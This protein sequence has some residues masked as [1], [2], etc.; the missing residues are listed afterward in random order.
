MSEGRPE[1][2][3]R[4]TVA[5]R[6]LALGPIALLGLAGVAGREAGSPAEEEAALRA[7][8]A[9]AAEQ[10]AAVIE[11]SDA[12]AGEILSFQL[13]LIE[14]DD[15][16]APVFAAVAAGTPADRAWRAVLEREIA[17]YAAGEDE[18]FRAR[19][20][21]L[22]DLRDRVLQALSGAEAP[23]ETPAEGA[24]LAAE[25]L[26]PSRFLE[27]DWRRFGGAALK[28]GSAASHVAMLARARG[29]PLLIGLGSA[30]ERLQPGAAAALDA[31][32]GLLL[33][34]PADSSRAAFDR[35]LRQAA[36]RRRLE[37]EFL[38][39]PA[40]TRDGQRVQALIN[41]DDPALLDRL[42]PA[43]CDGIGLARSEF[44]F[45]A[46]R[47]LPGEEA[48]FQVYRRLL[49]WAQGRPVTIRTLDAGGDKPIPGLT[50][51]GESNPFLG[52]RGLRLSLAR[53]EIFA[54]QLRALVRAAPLGDLKVM[55]PMVTRPDELLQ[56]RRLLEAALEHCRAA[57]QAAALP[58]LG[59]MVEV[60]AAALTAEDFP[61]DFY[62]IGS[63]DL[64]QYVTATG[65]DNDS[66]AALHDPRNPAVLELIGRVVA[67]GRARGVEVSLCGDMASDPALVPLLLQRGL[68]TLSAAPGRL[69]A[70]KAAV[71]AWASHG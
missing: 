20:A 24:I 52:L 27:T 2:T 63:N 48:Q 12:M 34:H 26:T 40:V 69:A 71:A 37:G 60:P 35:R 36:E 5:S 65:R 33:L 53:P 7:A 62:S 17:D 21:D 64:V 23:A 39:R 70:V 51:D 29:V 6:G 41:V 42:D 43:H 25:D 47:P 11:A 10:L 4:G 56:A 14:D 55:V 59:M 46:D 68:R 58:P 19:A 15:L 9:R 30:F 31:E 67:A 18:Y 28:A 16:L 50:P 45:R 38:P 32:Q 49:D 8:F 66:V 22:A 13:A 61:A 1:L 3:L 44:L 57:G 54:V